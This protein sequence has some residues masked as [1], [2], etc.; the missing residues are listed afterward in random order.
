MKVRLLVYRVGKAGLQEPGDEIT[1]DG[2]EAR[3]M[4]AAG[5]AERIG[6]GKIETAALERKGRGG[7]P[8]RRKV[9]RED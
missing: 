1:V 4:I 6:K 9:N 8:R 2:S 7:K 3:R 5:Q